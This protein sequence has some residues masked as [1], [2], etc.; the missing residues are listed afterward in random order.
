MSASHLQPFAVA[1]IAYGFG[2]DVSCFRQARAAG[3]LKSRGEHQIPECK[4]R[5]VPQQGPRRRAIPS[6]LCCIDDVVVNEARQMDHLD[7]CRQA[8]R[9]LRDFGQKDLDGMD[10]KPRP[11]ALAARV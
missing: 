9:G 4:R 5:V 6:R 3:L 1:H 2:Q 7:R 11:D 8:D 10:E